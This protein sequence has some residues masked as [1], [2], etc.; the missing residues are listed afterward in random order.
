MG[1]YVNDPLEIKSN[2][3]LQDQYYSGRAISVYQNG[4][5]DIDLVIEDNHIE[6]FTKYSWSDNDGGIRV[7]NDAS[8]DGN[9]LIKDNTIELY[10]GSSKGIQVYENADVIGNTISYGDRYTQNCGFDYNSYQVAI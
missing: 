3:I 6:L 5:Y 4:S 9:T 7:Y 2:T 8:Y 1:I 10:N